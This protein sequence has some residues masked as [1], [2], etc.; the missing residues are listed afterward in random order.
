MIKN[1]IL[2]RA[3][4]GQEVERPPVWLM[5]QAG[6]ILPQYRSLRASLSGFK[7]LVM[8]PSLAA[9]VTLQPVDE[10][11]VDAA[12][13]FSDILVIPEA[14]GLGYEMEERKGPSFPKVV[15]NADDVANL[16][17]GNAAALHLDYVYE[18]VKLTKKSLAGRVPLIGF[19]G[20][21]WTLMAYMTEGGGSKT[22]SKAKKFLYTQ[23]ELAHQLLDKL[24]NT[25]ISY[26]NLKIEAGVDAVQLFDSWAGVLS[27]EQYREFSFPYIKK[28]C[29]N[30]Q[31]VP[32]IVFAKDGWFALTEMAY[33]DC[34]AIGLDWTVNPHLG[35]EWVGP[36]KVLQGNLD[37]CA[38]YAPAPKIRQVTEQ[39]ILDFKSKHIVNLG[40]GLYPDTPLSNVKCFVDSVKS[41]CY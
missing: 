4:Q 39:M 9:E 34:Q 5:R 11:G 1:D 26:L 36:K 12:I 7:E 20:A 3:L 28:I 32:K 19:S 29:D 38:L 31:G 23:P 2:L 24:T 16:L 37:P 17:E 27:P 33:L 21:P 41:F 8:T 14:M 35:R 40:H 22:F 10:L 25:I 13:L 15:E 6:R 18:A 30:V